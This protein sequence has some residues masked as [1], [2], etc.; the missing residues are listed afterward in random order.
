MNIGNFVITSTKDYDKYF[1]ILKE[2]NPQNIG[3]KIPDLNAY[4]EK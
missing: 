1:E 4:Y 2:D 3:G